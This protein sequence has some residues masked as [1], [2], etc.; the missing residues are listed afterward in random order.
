ML[1]VCRV[2]PVEQVLNRP[3]ETARLVFVDGLEAKQDG[4]D[5]EESGS[6]EGCHAAAD[7]GLEL[8]F[9]RWEGD[10]QPVKETARDEDRR[11]D[12]KVHRDPI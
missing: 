10:G 11:P 3:A 8:E 5:L 7:T 9:R 6:D 12:D 4:A 2:G 1:A